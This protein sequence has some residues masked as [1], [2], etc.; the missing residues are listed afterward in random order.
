MTRERP[1]AFSAYLEGTLDPASA[2][3]SK[4]IWRPARCRPYWPAS[5]KIEAAVADWRAGVHRP[6]W[7]GSVIPT[8]R[9]FRLVP[10]ILRPSLSPISG[11]P[12]LL[13][14]VSFIFLAPQTVPSEGRQCQSTWLERGG[15]DHAKAG[16]VTERLGDYRDNL[17]ALRTL[18]ILKE[19]ETEE[20]RRYIME[21]RIVI[22][23][24]RPSRPSWRPS[25]L[26]SSGDRGLQRP[27]RQRYHLHRPL[28]RLITMQDHAHGAQPV[29]LL[30]PASTFS[31]S[32]N[33]STRPRPS[34]KPR[35]ADSRPRRPP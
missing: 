31:R 34:T 16:S 6:S 23:R 10:D 17:S 9:K 5:R 28:R 3:P 14:F 35:S 7:P 19:S 15:T 29:A 30:S 8:A 4:I 24:N 1:R 27:D 18:N 12:S 26:S 20:S 33:P 21:E 25:C 32:S 22:N 13:V 11:A 2:G